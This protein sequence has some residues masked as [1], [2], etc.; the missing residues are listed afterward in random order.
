QLNLA[1]QPSPE[2]SLIFMIGKSADDFTFADT[3]G[4]PVPGITYFGDVNG[5]LDPAGTTFD[6]T[7]VIRGETS[8]EYFIFEAQQY[9]IPQ[10]FYVAARYGEAENT[11]DLIEQTDNTV[12]RLQVAAGYWFN[13]RTLLK[14][15]YVEQDEGANSGGQIGAGFD[16]FTS[17]ISVKF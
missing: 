15:E 16:G 4:N 14:I 9:V 3:A 8:V 10:K 7:S 13:D 17:E 1:Y 5:V 6:S 12:E 11:S 2:T